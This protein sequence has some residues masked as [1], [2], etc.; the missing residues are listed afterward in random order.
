M[1]RNSAT[2]LAKA[3]RE[4]VEAAFVRLISGQTEKVPTGTRPTVS[5][6][7]LET[8]VDRTTIYRSY[9]DLIDRIHQADSGLTRHAKESREKEYRA[10]AEEAQQQVRLLA[11]INYRQKLREEALEQQLKDQEHLTSQ[12]RKRINELELDASTTLRRVK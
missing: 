4:M 10:L 2:S 11:N 6:L 3:S 12:L 5:A 8:G 9:P 7:A 1:K